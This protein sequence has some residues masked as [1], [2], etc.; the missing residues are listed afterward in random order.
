MSLVI[1]SYRQV[2]TVLNGIFI[3][4]T[5]LIY[6]VLATAPLYILLLRKGCIENDSEIA[7][8]LHYSSAR[9]FQARRQIQVIYFS[10][11]HCTSRTLTFIKFIGS[12]S[13]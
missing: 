11:R 1:V 2:G 4:K 6:V 7:Y 3:E 13:P 5:P 8:T 9:V 12:P 10:L